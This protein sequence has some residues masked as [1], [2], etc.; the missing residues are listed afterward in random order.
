MR[1]FT[2][3]VELID[4]GDQVPDIVV[5]YAIDSWLYCVNKYLEDANESLSRIFD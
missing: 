1:K 3:T 2:V 4:P 5:G